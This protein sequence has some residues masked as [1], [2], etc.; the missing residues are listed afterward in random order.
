MIY[1]MTSKEGQVENLT[2]GQ[3]H[4]LT[5]IGH[6][7]YHLMRIDETNTI[8]VERSLYLYSIK[9]YCRKTAGDLR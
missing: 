7:A 4:D 9:S 8:N 5:E 1:N 2:S 3:G 6:V